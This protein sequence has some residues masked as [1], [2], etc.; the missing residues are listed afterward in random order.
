MMVI[1]EG[2]GVF[3]PFNTDVKFDMDTSWKWVERM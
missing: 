2:L 3:P 1:S